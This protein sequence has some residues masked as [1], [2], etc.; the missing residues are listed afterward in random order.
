[1]IN[2]NLIFKTRDC[3]WTD[4]K[5]PFKIV[6]INPV[7]SLTLS[8]RYGIFSFESA[9]KLTNDNRKSKNEFN[10]TVETQNYEQK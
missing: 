10:D 2:S 4:K 8:I 7:F 6:H 5:P 9:K 1:M 3:W